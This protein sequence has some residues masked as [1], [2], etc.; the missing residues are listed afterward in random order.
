MPKRPET[1]T[2]IL[3]K[4]WAMRF[5]KL[6]SIQEIATFVDRPYQRVSEWV[7]Q[8]KNECD[9]SPDVL[10]KMKELAAKQ[11]LRIASNRELGQAYRGAYHAAC[12]LFPVKGRKK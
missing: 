11:T 12:I 1:A 2:E 4:L 9:R 3:N 6:V 5:I 10:A 8:R 7:I